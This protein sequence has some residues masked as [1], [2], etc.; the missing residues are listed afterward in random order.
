MAKK[1]KIKEIAERAG[2]SAG[3]VDRILHNRGKV[4]AQS[5]E[6]VEKV[7]SE[8]GYKYN[9]HL[10]AMSFRKEINVNICIP[11]ANSGEY[12]E[13]VKDGFEH[14]LEEYHDIDIK[15]HYFFYDQYDVYSC[16]NAYEEVIAK[17]T[18]AVIIGSTF[19]EDTLTFC[20]QLD[21]AAIP[22]VLVDSIVEGTKPYE[23]YTT[24]QYAC[25]YLLARL[26]DA[27]TPRG[28]S[29]AI[30][31]F[32]R[33]GDQSA[34][35]SQ[36]RSRGF[37]AYMNEN[38]KKGRV[39]ETTLPVTGKQQME[40][41]LLEFLAEH[42]DVKGIAVLNSKGSVLA[43]TLHKNGISDVQVIS[44]DLTSRNRRCL[45]TGQITALLCQKPELQGFN[46]IKSV[47]NK[48][49]YNL[50][51]QQVHHLMP[52]DV[53]FKENLPFYKEL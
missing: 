8:F 38:G 31:R 34:G 12:W 40:S 36:E 6:A 30:F 14:A 18:D 16:R 29:I 25:G 37:D 20:R 27:A 48:L 44:F 52:I 4:S 15:P 50:P 2:V 51:V 26:L 13:S 9:I 10:S 7:L 1:I 42:P 19:T 53:V 22:Y 41:T 43:E 47:I 3:T 46:A 5:R 32:Q 28:N 21:N 33:I 39:I 35:N 17:E 11:I 49:L 45:E 24:D 23:T